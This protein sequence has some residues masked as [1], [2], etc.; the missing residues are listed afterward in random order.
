MATPAAPSRR[1]RRKLASDERA[2]RFARRRYRQAYRAYVRSQWKVLSVAA[3][4]SLGVTA[5]V[6]NFVSGP[7]ARGLAIGFGVT[8]TA[9][10]LTHLVVLGSGA[11]PLMMGELAEQ[12]TAGE[13]RRLQR[14]DWRVINHFGLA[15]GDIDHVVIGSRG[16]FVI[17]TK[18]SASSWIQH[19]AQEDVDAANSQV[20][21][22]VKR[23]SMWE[24]YKRL[25]VPAPQPIVALWGTGS[26][27]FARTFNRPDVVGGSDLV[28]KLESWAL[29]A[30]RLT[31]DQVDSVWN[32]LSEHLRTRDV[33]EATDSPMPES[34]QALTIRL[35]CGVLAGLASFLAAAYLLKTGLP[36]W[37]WFAVV[38]AAVAAEHPL[39]RCQ[40]AQ[41]RPMLA[42]SQA[43]FVL[44]AL[45]AAAIAG[46]Q[47]LR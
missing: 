15:G 35:V 12:W 40:W 18:W 23:M 37:S 33:R 13:L 16:V 6:A 24:N 19:W 30:P 8:A 7:L 36:L 31:P 22:G 5:V 25:N 10:A 3:A 9:A 17:E 45:L 46:A 1:R 26:A 28:A 29:T 4:L 21:R 27:D 43:G 20:E 14:A 42:G 2:G 34:L 41:I 32:V 38:A 44:T 47:I 39:R 11:A